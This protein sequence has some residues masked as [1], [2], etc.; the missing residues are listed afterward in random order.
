MFRLCFKN[1]FVSIIFD[2]CFLKKL[3]SF[4]YRVKYNGILFY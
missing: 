1:V 3:D 4:G 2:I